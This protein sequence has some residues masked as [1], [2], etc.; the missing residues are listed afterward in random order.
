M[1]ES[2]IATV[3]GVDDTPASG[4]IAVASSMTDRVRKLE[5]YKKMKLRNRK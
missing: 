4:N 2:T 3:A 5:N 1:P